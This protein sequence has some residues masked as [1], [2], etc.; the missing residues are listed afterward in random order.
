[1]P[2]DD[3]GRYRYVEGMLGAFLGNLQAEVRAVYDLLCDTA[4]FAAENKGVF[5]SRFGDEGFERHRPLRLLDADDGISRFPQ[6][7]DGLQSIVEMLPGDAELRP[8][9]RFVDFGGR[10]QGRIAAENDLV[11]T[12]GIR[13]PEDRSGVVRA[14][15]IVQHDDRPGG[16]KRPVGLGADA[17]QFVIQ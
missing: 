11:D 3:S 15:D 5:A 16:R 1:M 10:G 6:R 14:P 9:G 12:E 8:E 13:R 17:S 4:H 2:E 7:P